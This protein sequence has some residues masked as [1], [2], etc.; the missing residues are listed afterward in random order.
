MSSPKAIVISKVIAV[1][2]LLSCLRV[3]QISIGQLFHLPNY[4]TL[5]GLIMLIANS[6]PF[7]LV[8]IGSFFLIRSKIEGFFLIYLAY[9]CSYFGISWFYVPLI[10]MNMENPTASIRL[11]Y[12]VNSIVVSILV[13]CHVLLIRN[14]YESRAA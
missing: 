7:F 5:S 9:L 3:A 14:R 13:T 12:I 11:T 6:V 2:L 10:P 1:V 8:V 4:T